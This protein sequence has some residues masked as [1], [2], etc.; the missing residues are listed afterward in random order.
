MEGEA[1]TLPIRI[2]VLHIKQEGA[3]RS[4]AHQVGK[5]RAKEAHVQTTMRAFTM[6]RQQ[7]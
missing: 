3:L 4:P 7:R 6:G 5:V 2:A 1:Q